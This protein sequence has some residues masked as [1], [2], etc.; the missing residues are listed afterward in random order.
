V[1]TEKFLEQKFNQAQKMQAIGQLAG[2]VA[3]DFNNLLTAIL[4]HTELLMNRFSP[5]DLTY[6]DLL[7]IRNNAHRAGN[8]VRQLLA[9]SRRQTLKPEI[10]ILTDILPDISRMLERLVG[11]RIILNTNYA[12][13]LHPIKADITQ[14]EQVIINLGVNARDAMEANGGVLTISTENISPT[15]ASLEG[16]NIMPSIAFVKITVSDTGHGMSDDIK[17]KIFEPFFTTKEQGKGTG[18]GL[19]TVYGIVKQSDG[20]V[21]VDSNPNQGTQFR[22]YFPVTTEQK[23][24]ILIPTETTEKFDDLVAHAPHT[25]TILIVEDEESVRSFAVRALELRGYNILQ[26]DCGEDALDIFKNHQDT[27]NL[28]ITDVMMPGLSGPEWIQE[29]LKI[30]N[31]LKVIFMSGYTQ[32]YFRDDDAFN[33]TGIEVTFL[34]KPF[35]LKSFNEIVQKKL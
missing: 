26:A 27:I 30:K 8:L 11:D 23:K 32:D 14:L 15:Q 3:H 22:V 35:S 13:S 2:G 18:L 1:S 7:Q 21:F 5:A 33:L 6:I 20:F 9:F 28:I 29:A 16:H 34:S 10:I 4:G 25:K 19:S 24:H 12:P 17:A 31:N